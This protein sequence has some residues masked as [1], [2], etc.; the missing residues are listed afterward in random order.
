MSFHPGR[1]RNPHHDIVGHATPAGDWGGVFL[2]SGTNGGLK[3]NRFRFTAFG[4]R[5]ARLGARV[6][7]CVDRIYP[8]HAFHPPLEI[9]CAQIANGSHFPYD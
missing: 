1:R 3:Q 6:A 7:G 4:G 8:E 2:H 9:R 5:I